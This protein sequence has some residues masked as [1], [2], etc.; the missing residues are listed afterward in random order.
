MK[1]IG[2][3]ELRQR[4]SAV[5][6]LVETGETFEVTDRGRP[7]ALIC[8]L[9]S[10]SPLDELRSIGEVSIPSGDLADLPRPLALPP[11]AVPPSI[12]LARLRAH[13]R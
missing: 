11:R 5:L 10:K 13:E 7:V 6:R 2:V 1:T 9:R 8:P 3:R 4:A 12:L